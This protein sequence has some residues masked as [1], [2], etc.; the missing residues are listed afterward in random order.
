MTEGNL[1]K[2][3]KKIYQQKVEWIKEKNRKLESEYFDKQKNLPYADSLYEEGG[4]EGVFNELKQLSENSKFTEYIFEIMK[5]LLFSPAYDYMFKQKLKADIFVSEPVH[6]FIYPMY[7][8]KVKQNYN[9]VSVMKE[10]PNLEKNLG[11]I[12]KEANIYME[13]SSLLYLLY[14]SDFMFPE[15]WENLYPG[16][17]QALLQILKTSNRT[18]GEFLEELV[19][20]KCDLFLQILNQNSKEYLQKVE[21]LRIQKQKEVKEYALVNFPLTYFYDHT[22]QDFFEDRY[23]YST[24]N[25]PSSLQKKKIII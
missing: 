5:T 11:T 10:N 8:Q 6:S 19:N 1:D 23:Q 12:E 22:L 3:I 2:I 17:N 16:T 9:E 4:Y 13:V 25:K 21:K 14:S 18:I 15:G 24:I 20:F 7:E